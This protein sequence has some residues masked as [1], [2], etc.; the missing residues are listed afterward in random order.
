MEHRYIST[1]GA[2]IIGAD[3]LAHE[4]TPDAAG[5]AVGPEAIL[6]GDRAVAVGS[7]TEVGEDSVA[8]GD[9]AHTSGS[10]GVAIGSGAGATTNAVAIGAGIGLGSDSP[11]AIAIGYMA[12]AKADGIAIG[13]EVVAGPNEVVI[14]RADTVA[15]VGGD[16]A[17]PVVADPPTGD[18]GRVGVARFCSGNGALYIWTGSAWAIIG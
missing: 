15:R 10:N 2:L 4:T 9:R 7:A 17:L 18:P 13:R 14:G 6:A 8:V 11:G 5:V 1:D 12:D 16:F 3:A